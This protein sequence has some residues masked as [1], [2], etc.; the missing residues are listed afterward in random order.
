MVRR[1]PPIRE[2]DEHDDSF[3]GP[4]G[5]GTPLIDIILM[6]IPSMIS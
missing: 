6:G 2:C 4:F 1:C 3:V 5:F